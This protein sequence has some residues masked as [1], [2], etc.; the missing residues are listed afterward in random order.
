[1]AE[2][3][4]P[5]DLDLGEVIRR[6]AQETDRFFRRER[7]DPRFCLELFRRALVLRDQAAWEAIYVQYSP[8]VLSWVEQHPS[9]PSLNEEPDFFVN[10]AFSKLWSAVPPERFHQFKELKA[11][12]RYLKMCTGSSIIDHVRLEER[13]HQAQDPL[14]L[15]ILAKARTSDT[16]RE[17]LDEAAA[18]LLLRCVEE[19][20]R[21]P[22]E[23]AVVHGM[24]VLGLKPRDILAQHP[25]LFGTIKDVY[26]VKQNLMARLR[27]DKGLRKCW[28][29]DA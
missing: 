10:R 7:V 20:L 17:V 2:P 26:R 13:Y 5:Q 11:I 3:R 4:S 8:L 25:D 15:D 21:S 9:F 12:L 29:E 28:G 16:E 1:M 6:C 24:F 22:A 14:G 23:R 18:R 19:R 27:R